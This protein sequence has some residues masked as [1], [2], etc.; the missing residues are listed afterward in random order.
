MDRFSLAG[1]VALVT[2]GG[3]GIGAG[4][5]RGFAEAGA[6]VAVVAR[7]QADVDTVVEE[8]DA[9]GGRAS[10]SPLTSETSTRSP[11]SSTAPSVSSAAST[12][13]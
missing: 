10:R 11:Q 12:S 5:A 9:A 2:G 7:T 1:R 6:T 13:S 8:I 4:I 3:R